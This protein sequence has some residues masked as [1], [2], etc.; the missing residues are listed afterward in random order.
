[1]SDTTDPGILAIRQLQAHILMKT[2]ARNN[3]ETLL[4]LLTDWINTDTWNK[5]QEILQA[6]REQ[7]LSD[8]A[9]QALEALQS[10]LLYDADEN[11][12]REYILRRLCSNITLF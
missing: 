11:E 6:H 8:E 10:S 2:H 12:E 9:L 7:L 4:A 5:S 3:R 1:M